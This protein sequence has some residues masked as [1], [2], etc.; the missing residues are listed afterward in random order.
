MIHF[1]RK[2]RRQLLRENRFT[3]YVL[4]ALGEI[5]LVVV[6]ILIA[7]EVNNLNE[8]NKA[9]DQLST[10]LS[11]INRELAMNIKTLEFQEKVN[12]TLIEKLKESL[13][14]LKSNQSDSLKMLESR[15]G[16]LGTDYTV[17]LQMPHTESLMNR[18]ELLNQSPDSL[19]SF[20]IATGYFLNAISESNRYV[21]D[22]YA[23]SIEPYFYN[24]INYA[25]VAL[26][27]HKNYLIPGGPKTDFSA[28]NDNMYLWNLITFKLET[29]SS[30]RDLIRNILDLFEQFLKYLKNTSVV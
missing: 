17:Q 29:V 25:D 18:M 2:I 15:I 20:L 22:Q 6:G 30:Q 21:H 13:I 28:I 7:L 27:H 5:F 19:G 16:A 11:K 12:D 9:R 8:R 10:N 23:N 4:Y 1:F 26:D 24:N 14:I 3:R